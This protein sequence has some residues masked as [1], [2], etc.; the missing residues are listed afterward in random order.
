MKVRQLFETYTSDDVNVSDQPGVDLST[1]PRHVKGSFI[2]RRNDLTSMEGGPTSV[3]EDYSCSY[4]NL[5]DLK[6][7][8]AIIPGQFLCSK[9]QLTTLEH[10]PKQVDDTYNC[11]HNQLTSLKGIPD[12]ISGYLDCGHNPLNSFEGFPKSIS[13]FVLME[14]TDIKSLHNI[15][16]HIHYIGQQLI[17]SRIHDSVLGVLLIKGL[18]EFRMDNSRVEAIVNYYLPNTRGMEAVFEC[19]EELIE[20]GF[21]EYAQL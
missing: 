11:G 20:A 4:N 19:Q 17:C 2:C 6:G 7:V 15:H 8:P 18:K 14:K 16:K 10:G 9:N 12:K 21:E 1:L 3:G 5:T 13:K